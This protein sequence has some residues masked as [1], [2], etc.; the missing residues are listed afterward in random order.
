[1]NGMMQKPCKLVK[2]RY[3]YQD[4][5]GTQMEAALKHKDFVE[6]EGD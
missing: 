6:I 4:K 3:T 1:M 2:I 5:N